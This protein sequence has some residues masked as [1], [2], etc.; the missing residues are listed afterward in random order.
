MTEKDRDNIETPL[1]NGEAAD[2]EIGQEEIEDCPDSLE[3]LQQEQM[4]KEA[5]PAMSR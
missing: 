5:V 3:Q 4:P 1:Q 2:D